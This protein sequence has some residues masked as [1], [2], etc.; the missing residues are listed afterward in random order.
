MSKSDERDYWFVML[1]Y[2]GGMGVLATLA[3]LPDF[4]LS[5]AVAAGL[6]VAGLFWVWMTIQTAN[7]PRSGRRR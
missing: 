5:S 4:G 6:L 7:E 1:G 2:C 3:T